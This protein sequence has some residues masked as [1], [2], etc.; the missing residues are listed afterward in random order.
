V[1]AGLFTGS[2]VITLR[3]PHTGLDVLRSGLGWAGLVLVVEVTVFL[4]LSPEIGVLL[5][6]YRRATV[7]CE[8]RTSALS[9]TFARLHASA[10]W[11]RHEA[12]LTGGGPMDVWRELCWRLLVYPARIDGREM[13][14]V[15]AVS[16]DERH[17]AVRSAVVDPE[18]APDPVRTARPSHLSDP[19]TDEDSGPSTFVTVPA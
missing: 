14:V 16:M 3:V 9:E 7:P 13:E 5:T 1:R 15:F 12:E 10:A 18:E 6:H 4:A 17:P 2:A 19:T 8:L 11:R